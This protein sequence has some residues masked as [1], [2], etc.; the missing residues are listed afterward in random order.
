[1]ANHHKNKS[2]STLDNGECNT[3]LPAHLKMESTDK[4]KRS[5]MSEYY[6]SNINIYRKTYQVQVTTGQS[7][8]SNRSQ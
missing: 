1:M 2:S 5:E 8:T 7:G 6:Q 3:E 4:I